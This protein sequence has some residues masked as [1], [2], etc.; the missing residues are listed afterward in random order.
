MDFSR[1]YA[2]S[3]SRA[4]IICKIDEVREML[5]TGLI[6]DPSVVRQAREVIRDLERELVA[7]WEV[8]AMKRRRQMR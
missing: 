5:R 6:T 4:E 2:E 1:K 7:R 8:S 3:A